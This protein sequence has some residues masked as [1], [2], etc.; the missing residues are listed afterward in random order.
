VPRSP[1]PIPQ[2]RAERIA[3]AHACANCGEYSYKRLVVK[4]AAASLRAE[5]GEVWHVSKV[6]GVCGQ[7]HEMGIDAVGDIVYVS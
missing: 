7:E 1:T 3:K 5:L 6:C 2:E 4:R